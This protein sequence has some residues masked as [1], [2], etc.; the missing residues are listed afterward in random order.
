MKFNLNEMGG[1]TPA[2]FNNGIAGKVDDVKIEVTKKRSDEADNVP[3]YKLIFTDK[4][5]LSV[6]QGFFYHKN[7]PQ[8]SEEKN[9]KNAS[10][11]IGRIHSAAKAVVPDDFEFPE[12]EDKEVNEIMDILF[13]IIRDHSEDARVNVFTVYGNSDYPSRF[14]GLR[15][16][17]FVEKANNTG[18]SRLTP[19]GNDVLTRPVEDAPKAQSEDGSSSAPTKAGW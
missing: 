17:D 12:V 1:N 16:F 4:N 19:K 3:D 15:F 13:K 10:M 2:V 8:N 9:A 7:N 14:L 5:G 11:L 6:N 18:Y